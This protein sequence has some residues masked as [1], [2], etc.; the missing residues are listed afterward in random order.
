MKP[1]VLAILCDPVT[2]E[3]L[4]FRTVPGRDG[5]FDEFLVNERSGTQYPIRDGIPVFVRPDDVAGLNFKYQT[6]YNRIARFY[7]LSTWLYARFKGISEESRLREYL[8]ELEIKAGACVL[9]V[10]VGTGRNWKY[11]PKSARYF[12]LDLSWG[13]L[14]QCQRNVSKWNLATELFMGE[15]ENLPFKDH[16]FDVVYHVGGINYFNDRAK[17][18]REM[19]RVARPG[20][21]LIIVDE[22]EE[23]AK[24]YERAPVTGAFYGNRPQ[25]IAAPVDL[26]P[27]GMQDVQLRTIANGDLYCLA[28]RT[29]R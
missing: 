8:D 9:E 16:A 2:H 6:L 19:V 18:I 29:P 27:P 25:A 23:L 24:K 4:A 10:S 20:T 7:D 11:L 15:A 13:M 5:T 22:S 17:A 3:P 26:V 14:K 21:K 12:G 28:F 1:D